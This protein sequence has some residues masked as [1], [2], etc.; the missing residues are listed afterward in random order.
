MSASIGLIA[1]RLRLEEKRLLDA[2]A[3]RNVEVEVVDPR[4]L[5]FGLTQTSLPWQVA[6]N[7]EISGTRARYGAL[8]L[9]AA[10][11]T[12]LNS[13]KAS[14]IC[15]DKWQTSVAL[16]EAGVPTPHAALA[17]TPEAALDEIAEMGYPVVLKPL[18][19]SWGKRVSL[20]RDAD[21]AEAV[22]EHCAALP[23][24]QAHL[25]YL[26]AYVEKPGRDI[27]VVVVGDQ[28]VGA[29]YRSSKGWR[30]NVAKGATTTICDL[31]GDLADIAIGAARAVGADI[32]GVDLVEDTDGRL[33]VL[34][35]NSGVEFAGLQRALG[36]G[37]DVPG[38]IADLVIERAGAVPAGALS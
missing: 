15:G 18:S 7:R 13:A 24:P 5:R 32:A 21:A 31:H 4:A 36:E 37:C 33:L 17:L 30:T 12:T 29:I 1:S 22:L 19:S 28:A 25:I 11:V 10:G 2:F 6:L 38:K 35:V 20:I 16:R 3:Q 9:E 27:R 14:E 26:Q 34:E 8:S 23:S